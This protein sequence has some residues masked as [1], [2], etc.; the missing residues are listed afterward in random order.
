MTKIIS[1]D[2]CG[3]PEALA[4]YK[5]NALRKKWRM[6]VLMAATGIIAMVSMAMGPLDIPVGDIFAVLVHK[7]LPG[8][9]GLPDELAQRTI[10][11]MRL[12]RLLMGLCA[13]FSLA[14]AGAVMQPVLRNPL[15]SPFTLGISAGAGFGAALAILFGKGVGAGTFFVV[16]N[17]FV[18][19]LF[20]A[21][22]I[23]A[24]ARYKGATPGNMVL[25]GIAL[26][27]LFS[28]GT[29]MMQYFAQS[30]AVAEVVFWMVGSLAKATWKNLSFMLPVMAV[31]L[32]YLM[33]KSQALNLM[34]TGDDVAESLGASVRHTRMTVLTAA[35]LLTAAT[36]C[37]TGTIGFI[38]LVGPHIARMIF[39][40]DNRFVI[41]ASGL[42]GALL[43]SGSDLLAM[44]LIA[45]TVLPIGVMTSFMGVPLFIYLIVKNRNE[46]WG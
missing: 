23:L 38:G 29:T 25:A 26:S 22:V 42:I 17:A 19:A 33:Y 11:Y 46:F 4:A 36:I 16:I 39:G 44:N 7:I 5:H 2:T 35:S 8:I 45:P 20:T 6:M 21:L 43:L 30:W 37:F 28:A 12:P 27:Y 15:A 32:P 10:W 40:G 41:P 24:L 13:G 31:C 18:F 14:V 34:S 1:K 3:T 9:W